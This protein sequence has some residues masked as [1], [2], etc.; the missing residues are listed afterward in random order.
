[1]E[2]T[3]KLLKY[4]QEDYVHIFIANPYLQY[5]ESLSTY[6]GEGNLDKHQGQI[7]AKKLLM[8]TGAERRFEPLASD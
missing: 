3:G 1:M 7:E 6:T 2:T 5:P 4:K 8:Y